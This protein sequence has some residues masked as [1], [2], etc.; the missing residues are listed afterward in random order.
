MRRSLLVVILVLL[1]SLATLGPAATDTP[2][3]DLLQTPATGVTYEIDSREKGVRVL[4]AHPEQ[5]AVDNLQVTVLDVARGLVHNQALLQEFQP[6]MVDGALAIAVPHAPLPQATYDV[7]LEIRLKP[8]VKGFKKV[9]VLDL[10]ISQPAAQVRTPEPLIIEQSIGPGSSMKTPGLPIKETSGRSGL[11]RV[12]ILQ[13]DK[14]PGAGG[15]GS[16]ALTFQPVEGIDPGGMVWALYSLVKSGDL[17]PGTVK[18]SL[19]INA[20]Q[21][22]AP[23]LVPFE[24]HTRRTIWWIFLFAPFGLL[25]GLLLRTVLPGLVSLDQTRLQAIDLLS[26]IDR[27]V[28]LRQDPDFRAN[29]EM[30]R[31]VLQTATKDRKIKAD[32]L[33]K[34]VTHAV[35]GLNQELAAL[36]VRLAEA[37]KKAEQLSQIVERPWFVPGEMTEILTRGAAGLTAARQILLQNNAKD[38]TTE[39]NSAQEMLE[40]NLASPIRQWPGDISRLLR[41]LSDPDLPLPVM[42]APWLT[43]SLQTV[44]GLLS[45]VNDPGPAPDLPT[46]EQSLGAVHKARSGVQQLL[47]GIKDWPTD[48]LVEVEEVLSPALL[49]DTGAVKALGSTAT[50]FLQTL[51]DLAKVPESG[52]SDRSLASGLLKLANA[53]RAALVA[54]VAPEQQAAILEKLAAHDY[55]SAA[56]QA[57]QDLQ[58][59]AAVRQADQE[60]AEEAPRNLLQR[61]PALD[62]ETAYGRGVAGLQMGLPGLS[63][64]RPGLDLSPA[65]IEA[66]RLLVAQELKRVTALRTTL[67]WVG[68]IGLSFLLFRDKIGTVQ[69]FA[70]VFFWGFGTDITADAFWNAAKGFKKV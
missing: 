19:E 57:V 28:S 42:M 39:L 50:E 67:V 2:A 45:G 8:E 31:G 16:P 29:A 65:R 70:E 51:D 25:F 12:K 22:A 6:T 48:T 18:G 23:V 1:S 34:A 20:S 56:R 15:E 30:I 68:V 27:E 40:E 61:M 14:L 32:D 66:G 37:R 10:R 46:L 52:N 21:L 43:A 9:Q 7:R 54:Q 47:L 49:K 3:V 11:S 36:E 24:I 41:I 63:A 53:W 44:S 60:G 17:P 5:I 4:L 55:R 33:T 26:R 62:R 13:L 58:T 59:V 69:D 38:A 64:A 35:D